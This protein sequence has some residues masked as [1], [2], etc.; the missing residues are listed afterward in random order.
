MSTVVEMKPVE[1]KPATIPGMGC[2]PHEKGVAF[3]VWAPHAQRV[4]VIGT[5]NDWDE[6]AHPMQAEDHG[7]WYVNVPEAKIDD[8]YRFLIVNGDKKMSR[9]DPYARD[10]TSSVGNGVIHDPSFDWG[11]N[12]FVMHDFNELVI[13]EMHVGTF[14]RSRDDVPGT[15]QA[16]TRKF[17]YLKRLGVNCIQLMPTAEFAGDISWG[18]NPAHIFA[19]ES[20]YGGP[21]G[22]KHLVKIAHDHGIAVILDVVYNHFGPS[23]LDLWQ[24]DGWS[25]NNMGGIYFFNDW[26]A[27]TPWG[28]TRPDYGRGEVR[29]YIHDNAMM[30]LDDY[31]MDGLR[32]D[33]TLF[34]R[35]V[36]GT[37]QRP[38]PEG[39]SLTQWMN[40]EIHGR[41]PNKILIAEDLQNKAELTGSVDAGG[42]GFNSQWDAGFVHPIRQAVREMDDANRSMESIKHAILHKYNADVFQRVVYSESHDEVANGK[43]RVPSEVDPADP[44]SVYA[45]RRSTLAAALVFTSPGIPMLFQGQE[46]LRGGWFDD[47][48][49]I[50]WDQ[51]TDCRGI[52]RLYRDLIRLRRNLQGCSRG[53]TGQHVEVQHCDN[54]NKV[55]AFRRWADGGA[56]DDVTVIANFG[57][58]A[59][60]DYRI[61]F[62]RQGTWRLRFNSDAKYYSADF[63]D[64]PAGDVSPEAKKHDGLPFSA[65]VKLAPYS[66]LIYSEEKPETTPKPPAK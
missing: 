35:S 14:N 8:E 6:A 25:Q 4:S 2:M 19:V 38:L 48:Q 49:G 22:L 43:S 5:F 60:E 36:D 23:D 59:W 50:D 31:H 56:G 26:R 65:P 45:Q 29:S 27:S 21:I 9:I 58:R 20:A 62:V 52:V 34:I 51:E 28:H 39:W 18:Y 64:F 12:H 57:N 66:V 41:W 16:V 10:V 61:G 44:T 55:I 47:S 32:Y 63:G 1:N 15:F 11:D 54:L 3:R 40:R 37:E 42:A 24:F 17:D 13:Y 46:F 33:M 30:W 53:L 7:K